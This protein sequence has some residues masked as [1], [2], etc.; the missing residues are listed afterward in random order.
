MKKKYFYS[1]VAFEVKR[2]IVLLILIIFV[3][4]MPCTTY[5]L[6]ISDDSDGKC[7]KIEL[8][9]KKKQL[10]VLNPNDYGTNY[11]SKH[12]IETKN[13]GTTLVKKAI[14]I[15][16]KNHEKAVPIIEKLGGKRAAKA[17]SK[18]FNKVSPQLKSLLKW[19]D[20][21][22]QAVHDAV[23][24]GLIN[25]GVSRATATKAAHALKE[26]LTWLL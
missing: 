23:Y 12:G 19:S 6:T 21:P 25:A 3:I 8:I 17:F 11:V 4:A 20:V 16:L 5:A 10:P 7:T 15:V 26:G 22:Y 9:E 18:H 1:N 14:R 13:A 2:V 24:R